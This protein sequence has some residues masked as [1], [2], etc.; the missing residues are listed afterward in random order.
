M[1]NITR[2]GDT[3]NKHKKEIHELKSWAK[4]HESTSFEIAEAIYELAEGDDALAER[5]W[6]ECPDEVLPLAFSKTDADHLYWGLE[7]I[8]RKNV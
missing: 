2:T 8:D 5:I 4:A 3:M 1:I 6:E 7:R